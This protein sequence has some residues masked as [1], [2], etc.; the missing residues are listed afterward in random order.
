[1]AWLRDQGCYRLAP[2]S[3]LLLEPRLERRA[4]CTPWAVSSGQTKESV[5]LV[6]L[7]RICTEPAPQRLK[8]NLNLNLNL[9]PRPCCLLPF[10]FLCADQSTGQCKNHLTLC[11]LS[12][13]P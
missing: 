6:T 12:A 10:V 3:R 4:P 11:V 5:M 8:F 2:R 13:L 7:K 1:M 9:S